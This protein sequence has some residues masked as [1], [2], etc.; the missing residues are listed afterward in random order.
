MALLA[1]GIPGGRRAEHGAKGARKMRLVVKTGFD[2][3]LRKRKLS[4]LDETNG[5]LNA[6]SQEKLMR[7]QTDGR[8]KLSGKMKGTHVRLVRQRKQRNA[9]VQ[10]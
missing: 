7:R 8:T 10:V 5:P 3:Y 9:L 2:C 4:S 1:S 6:L